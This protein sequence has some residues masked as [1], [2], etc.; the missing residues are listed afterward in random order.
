ML[1][2]NAGGEK[3]LIELLKKEFHCSAKNVLK[4]IGDDAAV[5]QKDKNNFFVI[6]TDMIYEDDH[7]SLNYFTPKQIGIKAMESNV[8][9]IAAMG[10]KP[11]YA[12]ISIALTPD[13][14]IEFFE[15]FIK[16]IKFSAKKHKI[17]VLGGDTTHGNKIV[18]N[19]TLI[20]E[21]KKQDLVFRDGAKPG[22][23][24]FVSGNLGAST[25]GLELFKNK[26]KGFNS[27]K[28]KHLEPCAR[29]DIS[30]KLNKFATAMED[31]SDGLAS[32]VK[33]IC[34]ESNCGAIIFEKNIPISS[35]TIKAGKTLKKNAVDFAL[36][37]GEDFE[38]VFTVKKKDEKK[39][40]KFGFLVGET[41]KEKK[42]F[43]LE[44]GKLNLMEKTGFDHF[45]K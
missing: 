22:E 2:K 34:S 38:L 23:L 21:A 6:T 31:V 4:G 30:N 37:G 36:Y 40:K 11:V 8:S 26:I 32:E 43:L 15:E 13:T 1:I 44:K 5:I 7:F 24:I 18:V 3:F 42:V 17:M 19:I 41:I 12:F 35:E 25:A 39:A 33:N 45:K 14:T 10:A 20:G 16:G 28:K 29:T 27:V 9:D